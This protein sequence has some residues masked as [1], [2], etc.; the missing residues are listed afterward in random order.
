MFWQCLS[1]MLKVSWCLVLGDRLI[2]I[3]S[4]YS[5]FFGSWYWQASNLFPYKMNIN[6]LSL[7]NDLFKCSKISVF[8]T[9]DSWVGMKDSLVYT[10]CFCSLLFTSVGHIRF[11]DYFSYWW[12]LLRFLAC[13]ICF[14]MQRIFLSQ[15]KR[16]ICYPLTP[17]TYICIEWERL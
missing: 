5:P 11:C 7:E 6:Y 10:K 3:D 2:I 9:H 4:S 15:L 12:G 8:Q 1:P 16:S 13:C 14:L 17:L